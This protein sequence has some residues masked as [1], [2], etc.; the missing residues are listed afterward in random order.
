MLKNLCKN[1]FLSLMTS[2]CFIILF[3]YLFKDNL[4]KYLKTI[5]VYAV[6]E[7]KEKKLTGY[8]SYGEKYGNLIISSINLRLPIYYGDSE[9]ILKYGIGH[10]S[11]SYFPG[12]GGTII[13]A[14]HHTIGSL[15]NLDKVEGMIT[16][17]TDYGTFNYQIYDK[18]IIHY[19]DSLIIQHDEEILILYTCYPLDKSFQ[20]KKERLVLYAKKII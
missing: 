5:N 9:E 4:T 3:S 6:S 14:G 7:D 15:S 13:Y 10:Y 12:E 1:I 20:I 18:K 17:E 11:L 8:P 16:I 2:S 19:D